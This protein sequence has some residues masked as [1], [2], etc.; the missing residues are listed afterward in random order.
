MRKPKQTNSV[1]WEVVLDAFFRKNIAETINL[2]NTGIK[3]QSAWTNKMVDDLIIRLE[4]FK[5]LMEFKGK[6]FD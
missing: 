5:A 3:Q 6:Y 2:Q 1:F 4:T